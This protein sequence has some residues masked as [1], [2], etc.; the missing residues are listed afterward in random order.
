MQLFNFIRGQEERTKFQLHQGKRGQ[1]IHLILYVTS[2]EVRNGG[3]MHDQ[4]Q[5][6]VPLINST[7]R[8]MTCF[9]QRLRNP[10]H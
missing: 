8:E 4:M 1:A 3:K 10:N 9:C 2:E 5:A 7:A 6:E